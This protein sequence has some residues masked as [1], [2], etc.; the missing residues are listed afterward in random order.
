MA[1]G[2]VRELITV[3]KLVADTRRGLR[4][5]KQTT[6][7]VSDYMKQLKAA[8]DA[9]E[10]FEKFFKRDP[11]GLKRLRKAI[12]DAASDR[13]AAAK[14]R[15]ALRK[16][17]LAALARSEAKER[18]RAEAARHKGVMDEIKAL[19][20][21][22]QE[23]LKNL[24][25]MVRD[26]Q[27][28][29][30][31]M[32]ADTRRRLRRERREFSQNARHARNRLLPTGLVGTYGARAAGQFVLD[33]FIKDT[34]EAADDAA[35]LARQIGFTAD[36]TQEIAFAGELAGVKVGE[37][38]TALR[39][40]GDNAGDAVHGRGMA[41]QAFKDLEISV[42]D[43][44][45]KLHD[46]DALLMEITKRLEGLSER[47][48]GN[49]MAQIFGRAGAKSAPLV[50]G[51]LA[52]FQRFRQLAR[53]TGAV[54]DE[55]LTQASMRL[56]DQW[57]LVKMALFGI[58]N[59]LAKHLIPLLT[60]MSSRMF[61]WWMMNRKIIIQKM[62][63]WIQWL[64]SAF[65][66]LWEM[67]DRIDRFVNQ[68]SDW[69]TVLAVLTGVLAAL[70]AVITTLTA[71]G[72][73]GGLIAG[74]KSLMAALVFL[75]KPAGTLSAAVLAITWKLVLAA[76]AVALLALAVEDFATFLRGGESVFGHFLEWLLGSEEAAERVRQ[77]F[78]AV[79]RVMKEMFLKHVNDTIDSVRILVRLV[80]RLVEILG[81]LA[82]VSMT[83]R[84][85][86]GVA[87]HMLEGN[88]A[89]EGGMVGML[90]QQADAMEQA[91][92][93]RFVARGGNVS[94]SEIINTFNLHGLQ[95][96]VGAADSLRTTMSNAPRGR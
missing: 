21:R 87:G 92:M 40:M 53:D 90:N 49:I 29:Q 91:R 17:V 52:Q 88:V 83:L 63:K 86:R 15:T 59:D 16:R 28:A 23:A 39:R 18:A 27:R 66:M 7:A 1:N 69:G 6:A 34:A 48:I 81:L 82:N 67:L 20:K 55:S 42:D 72:L 9:Q 80:M 19:R 89:N 79:G 65:E 74:L 68:V 56:I 70:A 61:D 71:G 75:I 84:S 41:V 26:N 13:A 35:V 57:I 5:I 64:V 94:N 22:R 46:N 93:R 25:G 85:V 50:A 76:A 47:K 77:A 96:P 12:R 30:Q 10:K 37:L 45:G 11:K 31:T 54:I 2:P 44:N 33:R 51:G 8:S 36:A 73:I 58:R 3:V 32:L 38:K 60:D 95:D 78:E 4:D 14:K 24:R 62:D 43:L